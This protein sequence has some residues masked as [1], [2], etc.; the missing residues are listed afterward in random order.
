MNSKIAATASSAEEGWPR[1][2]ENVAQ[3]PSLERTGVVLS[4]E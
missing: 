3:H 1:H 4:I 2:Q